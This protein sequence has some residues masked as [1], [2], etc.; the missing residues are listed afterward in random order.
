[1]RALPPPGGGGHGPHPPKRR[2]SETGI[3]APID[4]TRVGAG[5][6][7]PALSIEAIVRDDLAFITRLIELFGVPPPDVED[8]V[9][10]V[11]LGAHRALPRY[12]GSR[13]KRRT[14]LYRIAF[15][16]AQTFL[17]RAHH[18]HE[19]CISSD[20]LER[21]IDDAPDAEAQLLTDDNQRLVVDLMNAIEINRRAVFIAYEIYG[22]R[23]L[24]IAHALGIPVSTGWGQLQAAR[25][26]FAD[27]L[28]RW[29]LC[30]GQP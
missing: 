14:W 5:P 27:A 13:G 8:V 1:M 28:R 22:M 30:R 29:Q 3:A 17:D 20:V 16:Q 6:L 7:P 15:N 21:F 24:D 25:K 2:R 19:V 26:D 18:R 9:Q 4:G 23:M 11:L 12:D 10:E